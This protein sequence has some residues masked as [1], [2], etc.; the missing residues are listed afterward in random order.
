LLPFK[1]C[2]TERANVTNTYLS[3]IYTFVK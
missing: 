3:I 2:S 1:N